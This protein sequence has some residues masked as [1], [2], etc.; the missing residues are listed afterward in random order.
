MAEFVLKFE[1][2]KVE[3]GKQRHNGVTKQSAG[4]VECAG[5]S[6]V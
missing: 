6:S 3:L 2:L 4:Y 5:D 1:V